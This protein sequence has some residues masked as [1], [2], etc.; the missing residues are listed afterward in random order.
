M[1]VTVFSGEGRSNWSA[2]KV[3]KKSQNLIFS[4][5]GLHCGEVFQKSNYLDN[6]AHF[7]SGKKSSFQKFV[8]SEKTL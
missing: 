5:F 3:G 4:N 7:E 8:N 2:K 6:Q 1:G